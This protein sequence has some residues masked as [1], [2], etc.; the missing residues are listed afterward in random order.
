M[1]VLISFVFDSERVTE[2]DAPTVNVADKSATPSWTRK[3]GSFVNDT[4]PNNCLVFVTMV[5]SYV[6][7]VSS[8]E[9]VDD[10]STE[11]PRLSTVTLALGDSNDKSEMIVGIVIF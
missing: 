7:T 6:E 2:N 8:N 9:T 3:P 11:L 4:V 10:C 1:A 5:V